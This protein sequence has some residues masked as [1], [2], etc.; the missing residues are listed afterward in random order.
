MII[1]NN[2]L[3]IKLSGNKVNTGKYFDFKCI[4]QRNKICCVPKQKH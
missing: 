3:I 1:V 4:S 2:K